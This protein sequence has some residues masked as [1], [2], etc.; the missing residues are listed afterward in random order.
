[1]NEHKIPVETLHYEN[2]KQ[3]GEIIPM[4]DFR[5]L[6]DIR[7]GEALT[8]SAPVTVPTVSTQE[9]ELWADLLETDMG[10]EISITVFMVK[11]RS[12][13]CNMME[14]HFNK[15]EILIPLDESPMAMPFA[16]SGDNKPDNKTIRVFLFDGSKAVLVKPGIWHWPPF[17]IAGPTT[18]MAIQKKGSSREDTTYKRV[19]GFSFVVES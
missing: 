17:P 12:F 2:F 4:K 5:V 11:H 16:L 6:S 8:G 15:P 7:I 18:L 9:V 10:G 3:F 14:S 13:N 19:E 1:M